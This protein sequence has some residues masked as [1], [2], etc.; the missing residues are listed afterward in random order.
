[1]TSSKGL[2]FCG[3]RLLWKASQGASAAAAAGAAAAGG[4]PPAV[5]I[6]GEPGVWVPMRKRALGF[7][8]HGLALSA[9]LRFW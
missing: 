4:A 9:C 1:M 5:W 2:N 8:S 6:F 7:T 3:S